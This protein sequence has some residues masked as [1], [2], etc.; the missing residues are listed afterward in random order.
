MSHYHEMFVS[1]LQASKILN[2]KIRTLQSWRAK[3]KSPPYI[4]VG[5][6]L[7]RYRMS[8]VY[9]WIDGQNLQ[10]QVLK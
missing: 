5:Q 10:V 4:K 9:Q 2:I 6:R 7:I 1:E 3:G 8:D